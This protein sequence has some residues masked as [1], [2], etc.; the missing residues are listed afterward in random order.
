ML[1]FSFES[2]IKNKPIWIWNIEAKN[3]DIR[4]SGDC[5][6]NH[7]IVLPIKAYELEVVMQNTKKLN[8]CGAIMISR[9]LSKVIKEL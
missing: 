3:E 7:I 9:I 4:T 8:L 2:A 5:C 6:F 1:D